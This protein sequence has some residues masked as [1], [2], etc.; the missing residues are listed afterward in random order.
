MVINMKK[1]NLNSLVL[2]LDMDVEVAK[3]KFGNELLLEDDIRF[4]ILGD[5]SR[6]DLENTVYFEIERSIKVRLSFG[7]RVVLLLSTTSYIS[8]IAKEIY[9]LGYS[10]YYVGKNKI[11]NNKH[12]SFYYFI[13]DNDKYELVTRLGD[14]NFFDTLRERGYNGITVIPDLHGSLQKLREA[15]AWAKNRRNFIMFL[16]DII[17]YG[18]DSLEVV[19]EVYQLVVNGDAEAILG[20][21][22]KKIFRYVINYSKDK[23]HQTN[24][25]HGNLMTV[26]R[27]KGLSPFDYTRWS[28]RFKSLVNLMRTHRISENFGFAHAA[29]ND[30]AINNRSFRLPQKLERFVLFGEHRDANGNS[31]F[32]WSK[33]LPDGMKVIVGHTIRGKFEPYRELNDNRSEVIFLDT[34]CG[35]GGHLTTLDIS[36]KGTAKI[37]NMNVYY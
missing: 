1:I 35:K 31:S 13:N 17:D 10:V 8:K 23:N 16:G 4:S 26:N 15:V 27:I 3:S 25:S 29:L 24:L 20:N 36:I 11:Q 2:L 30:E 34:G 18:M 19:E 28:N 21:H 37:E 5:T 22:E 12:E 14:D 32:N 33:D 7:N 6:E 9:E